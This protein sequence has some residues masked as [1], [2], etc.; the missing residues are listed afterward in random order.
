ME[1]IRGIQSAGVT[2]VVVTH[3]REV[4]AMTERV[5]HIRDGRIDGTAAPV[6]LAEVSGV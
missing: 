3:E 2:V 4:A 1:M 5:I 6:A